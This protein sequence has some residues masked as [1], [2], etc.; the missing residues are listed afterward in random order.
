MTAFPLAVLRDLQNMRWQE[1][2]EL[3]LLFVVIYLLLRF[4]RTTVAGGIFRG[5]AMLIWIPLLGGILLVQQLDFHVLWAVLTALVPLIALALVVTFQTELRHGVARLGHMRWL[6]GVF[7]RGGRRARKIHIVDEIVRAVMAFAKDN[8]GALIAVERQI[9]LSTYIS[10]GVPV[11]A[12]IRAETL[13]TIFS[14][15]TV[16]HDGAIVIRGNR[17][18][19]AGCLFPLTEKPELARKYGTRHRAAIGLS[20]QSDAVIIVVSEERGQINLAERGELTRYT[21]AGWLTAY[22]NVVFAETQGIAPRDVIGED[23]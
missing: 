4:L 21:D 9:D 5:G 15:H 16:L 11:D 8:V 20:E 22:L 18:A 14:T 7:S 12:I 17:I 2:V 13:D 23:E 19:A 1:Y 3:G 6:R 10:T